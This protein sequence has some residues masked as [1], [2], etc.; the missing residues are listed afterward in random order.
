[1]SEKLTAL[2]NYNEITFKLL[3]LFFRSNLVVFM[4]STDSENRR[5]LIFDSGLIKIYNSKGISS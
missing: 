2:F 5:Y 1:M 4:I 3:S